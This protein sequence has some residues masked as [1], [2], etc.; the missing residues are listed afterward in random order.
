MD[1]RRGVPRLRTF[2]GGSIIFGLAPSIDC[3]IRNLRIPVL[4]R[5]SIRGCGAG[6]LSAFAQARAYEAGVPGGLASSRQDRRSVCEGY[7]NGR[8]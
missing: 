4:V 3:I 1:E 2:K 6:P 7:E 8:K 5:S